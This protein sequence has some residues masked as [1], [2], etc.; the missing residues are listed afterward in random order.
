MRNTREEPVMAAQTILMIGKITLMNIL[1]REETLAATGQ[2]KY[3]I[4]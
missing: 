1:P 2:K 3:W 4:L